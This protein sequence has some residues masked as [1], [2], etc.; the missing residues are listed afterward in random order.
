MRA[1]ER[2]PCCDACCVT[3]AVSVMK[4]FC[5]SVAASL[6]CADHTMFW[7]TEGRLSRGRNLL[8]LFSL[9][10]SIRLLAEFVGIPSALSVPMKPA[11]GGVLTPPDGLKGWC[12][13]DFSSSSSGWSAE[14]R[15]HTLTTKSSPNYFGLQAALRLNVWQKLLFSLTVK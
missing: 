15:G 4:S 13:F 8:V 12:C 14:Q 7:R 1:R 11:V 6:N 9:L 5:L 2:E 10:Q 3:A